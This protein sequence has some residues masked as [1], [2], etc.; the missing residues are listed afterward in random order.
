MNQTIK[1]GVFISEL[2][3]FDVNALYH[4][5]SKEEVQHMIPDRFE[6]R[7]EMTEIVDWLISNYN[8]MQPVRL[9]YKL[10]L[11]KHMIGWISY[12][13][14]PSDKTKCEISCVIDPLYWNKG[15]ASEAVQVFLP[16]IQ[17]R[18]RLK[19]IYA[20]AMIEDKASIK[21]LENNGFEKQGE[22]LCSEMKVPKLLFRKA[23]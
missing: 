3:K 19:E 16:W 5:M 20:E 6:N 9:T 17:H 1:D 14:L 21:I 22:F 2:E 12:G 15:Y 18:L 7:E 8:K 10:S 4:L 13:P 11:D 23:L